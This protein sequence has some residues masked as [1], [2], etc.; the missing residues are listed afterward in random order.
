MPVGAALVPSP[1]F[2]LA[3]RL[4]GDRFRELDRRGAG[5]ERE[6]VAVAVFCL[7]CSSAI[8]ASMAPLMRCGLGGQLHV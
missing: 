3:G 5:A 6:G 7:A 1:S 8:R 4:E 2:G